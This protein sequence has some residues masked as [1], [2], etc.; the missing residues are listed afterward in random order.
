MRLAL[1][2]WNRVA[3]LLTFS[4]VLCS[5]AY[6]EDVGKFTLLPKGGTVPFEATCFDDVATARMLTW[7]EFQEQEFQNRLQL[8][9]GLQREE[10]TLEINTL[11]IHLE[12]ST[13]RYDESLRLRDEEIESLRKIIKKDRK[14]NLPLV[15]AGSVAVGVATGLG[16]A[17]ALRD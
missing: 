9:L 5:S 1:I 12:E 17:Y 2:M 4:L 10:L 3:Q 15:I 11:K 6:A 7:R 8:R 14:V 13:I 16:I